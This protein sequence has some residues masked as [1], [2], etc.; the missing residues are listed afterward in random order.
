MAS[1]P[2]RPGSASRST[3]SA[4]WS[5]KAGQ[6][7]LI[8]EL[9]WEPQV[10]YTDE[11][12]ARV[13]AVGT[14]SLTKV[15]GITVKAERE[16]A[17]GEAAKAVIDDAARPSSPS[18]SARSTTRPRRCSK[19]IVRRR[20]VN[21]GAR[22]DGRTP[23][24]IRPLSAEVGVLPTAHGSGLFQRG[25]TQVLNVTTLGM[26]KTDQILDNLGNRDR[27]RYMHHYNMPPHANGETG[28][29]GSP[30]RREIGHGLLAERALLPVVPS[31]DEFPYVLRLVSEVLASNGSTSMASVCSS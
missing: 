30:K 11:I 6:A 31:Q 9:E 22:M 27:K 15:A 8:H 13:E 2:P 25:E 19:K 20:I 4:S 29:V 1:R 17:Q 21:E 14:E 26:P 18:S 10:D 24:D 12:A 28:R 5:A 16:A 23:T 3:P 7:G